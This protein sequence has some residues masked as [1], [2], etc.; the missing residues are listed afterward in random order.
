MERGLRYGGG[1]GKGRGPDS[2]RRG[3]DQRRD[4]GRGK[5]AGPRWQLGRASVSAAAVLNTPAARQPI[6]MPTT[7][8]L[9]VTVDQDRCTGCAICVDACLEQAISVDQIAEIDIT[10][11]IGCCACIPVCQSKSLSLG[12]TSAN[13]GA[14][15]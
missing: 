8:P 6:P 4:S 9:I 5:G 14:V 11:C 10:R 15:G 1:K 2:G 3:T 13:R 7:Y 12:H